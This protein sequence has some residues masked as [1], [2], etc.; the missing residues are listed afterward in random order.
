M[1]KLAHVFHAY[2]VYNLI[3]VFLSLY[4]IGQT[5][6]SFFYIIFA[7]LILGLHITASKFFLPRYVTLYYAFVHPVCE[8]VYRFCHTHY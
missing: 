4:Y 1:Y 7:V 2:N 5:A 6:C 3:F 8:I